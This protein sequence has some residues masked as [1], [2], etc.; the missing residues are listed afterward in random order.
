MVGSVAT[1]MRKG[2]KWSENVTM[3]K[4]N[5]WRFWSSDEKD[6]TY[7][8][9]RASEQENTMRMTGKRDKEGEC[10][11]NRRKR[12]G[13]R[14]VNKG[15]RREPVDIREEQIGVDSGGDSSDRY[16]FKRSWMNRR[17]CIK[18]ANGR[19]FLQNVSFAERLAQ[20]CLLAIANKYW[21]KASIRNNTK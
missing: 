21:T 8:Q 5:E 16:R 7:I 9:E 17:Y 12:G 18:F 10:T 2:W 6:E 15:G 13:K 11:E 20:N 4:A 3:R 19:L 14:G 1:K